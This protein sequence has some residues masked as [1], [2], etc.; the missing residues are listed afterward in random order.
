LG[1]RK[2][3][4]AIVRAFLIDEG[5]IKDLSIN[6]SSNNF[7][8]LNDLKSICF[9]LDYEPLCI[10][11]GKTCYVLSLS[12]KSFLK[13]Y[14]DI[15]SIAPLP[16]IHKQKRLELG[17]KLIKKRYIHFDVQKEI[18][19]LLKIKA[20]TISEL[21]EKITA[22]RNNINNHLNKLK[23][24]NIIEICSNKVK[25]EFIWKLSHPI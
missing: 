5:H 17:L 16:I 4:V 20:M 10:K 14:N 18:K 12:T 19:N 25:G 15:M 23:E 7:K 24:K 1:D 6:F 11:K 9:N 2:L 13:F 8:L 22:R 3:L 21:C